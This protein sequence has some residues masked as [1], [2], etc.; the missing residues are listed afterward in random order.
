MF[1]S[2][3]GL[4]H[5]ATEVP[6]PIDCGLRASKQITSVAASSRSHSRELDY[7][8][9]A[10]GG[11][12]RHATRVV[13]KHDYTL[14]AVGHEMPPLARGRCAPHCAGH[15]S[16]RPGFSGGRT[17]TGSSGSRWSVAGSRRDGTRPG[18]GTIGF[19]AACH[20]CPPKPRRP[21][22]PPSESVFASG[23]DASNVLTSLAQPVTYP[24]WLDCDS[25]IEPTEETSHGRCKEG[26]RPRRRADSRRRSETNVAAA[27]PRKP[28]AAAPSPTQIKKRDTISVPFA[29]SGASRSIWRRRPHSLPGIRG[30]T[31]PSFP[32]S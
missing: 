27:P 4:T 19:A 3:G 21:R 29:P 18:D 24:V 2:E 23:K 7:L 31:P 25:V 26:R 20:E 8:L 22:R 13:R 17:S 9:K 6:H 16:L 10:A 30:P 32:A 1:L 15:C 28:P 5:S 12:D 11:R 14:R